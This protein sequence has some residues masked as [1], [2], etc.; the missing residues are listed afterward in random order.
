[1]EEV[2]GEEAETARADVSVNLLGE[3]WLKG[4]RAVPYSRHQR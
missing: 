4:A 1:M 2:G 3:A